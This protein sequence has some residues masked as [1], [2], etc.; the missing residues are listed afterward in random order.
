MFMGTPSLAVPSLDRLVQRS[1]DVVAVVT[2]P[3]RPVGR[4]RAPNAPAAKEAAVRLNL[5]VLQPESLRESAAVDALRALAPDVIAVVAYGQILRRAVLEIPRLGCVNLHP[6][7]LPRYRGATPIPAAIRDGL[8][9]TGITIMLMDAGMDTGPILAQLEVPISPADTTGS[10]SQKL[11]RIGADLLVSTMER[12]GAGEIVPRQQDNE[13][14][15]YTRQ[16]RK[17]DGAVD[18]RRSAVELDRQCRANNPWPGCFT[19]WR[20]NT[21]R[22]TRVR[23]DPSWSGDAKPGTV[24][25]RAGS[26]GRPELAVATSDGALIVEQLQLE[27]RKALNGDDFVRGQQSFVGSMLGAPPGDLSSSSSR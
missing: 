20:D 16:L 17:E 24:F 9:V 13:Q 3:D 10:L 6:S 4:N 2:Q 23:P 22:L 18:W 8:S 27:G 26:G 19:Y 5:P 11:A 1:F 12:L 15:T 14:A 25:L 21:V 7:L